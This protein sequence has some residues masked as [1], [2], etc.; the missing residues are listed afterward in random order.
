MLSKK[1]LLQFDIEES[2]INKNGL[3][4]NNE[5]MENLSMIQSI[6]QFILDIPS[7]PSQS[8]VIYREEEILAVGST[9][10]IEGNVMS[11][12]EITD[13]FEKDKSGALLSR[14]EQE[15]VNSR[16]VFAFVIEYVDRNRNEPITESVI[17]EIHSKLTRNI[18][19]LSNT[20]G[21]YRT[22]GRSF[23]NPRRE[24]LIVSESDVQNAMKKFIN[25]LNDPLKG[26]FLNF[27]MVKA[28]L[29]HYYLTEIHPFGD[30][31]GRTARALEALILYKDNGYNQ[32][33][34]WS[35]PNFVAANRDLYLENLKE[36]YTN[37]DILPFFRFTI[38]GYLLQLERIKKKIRHRLSEIMFRNYI[39]EL[40]SKTEKIKGKTKDRLI[41]V[42]RLL[43][44]EGKMNL[45]DLVLN[46]S[47]AGLYYEKHK[48]TIQRDMKKLI[49]FELINF[50]KNEKGEIQVEL[51]YSILDNITYNI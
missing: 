27:P 4:S 21:E 28:N 22:S 20:P 48:R 5:I 51:N 33:C 8:E 35:L 45:Q 37:I 6:N 46:P 9:E 11:P 26:K 18:N 34:F 47:F 13:A 10:A 7:L 50:P 19:Y 25:W 2:L 32:Y 44:N 36:I 16:N 3:I 24:C 14:G 40:F 38:R 49:S 15:M 29:A 1:K 39:E 41:A 12:E 43:E 42:I 23:G 31:N 17:R 30:G